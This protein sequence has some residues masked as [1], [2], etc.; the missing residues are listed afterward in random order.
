MKLIAGLGNPEKKYDNTF[1]N[2]GF[3]VADK[4]AELLDV[5]FS[6]RECDALVAVTYVKGE[7]VIIAKPQTY[8][9]LSGECIG[10]LQA[11]YKLG[12]AD[13]IAA[14]DDCDIPAA[15]IRIRASG[16]GGTH[17]GMRNAVL[18]LESEDFPR[19][20]VG[21]GRPAPE[22]PLANYVLSV[23]PSHLRES[24]QSAVQKAAEA[25]ALFAGG[26]GIED[27]MQRYN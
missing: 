11:R 2:L 16:S 4:A 13:I 19:I 9:N 7:K 6:K 18:C 12:L 1:H 3:M 21:I 27:I 26:V 24:M 10:R 20:R 25:A 5:K 22:T 23:I 15:T 17:N 14:Y 8:M